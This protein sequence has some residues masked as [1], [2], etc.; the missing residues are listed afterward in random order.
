MPTSWDRVDE[1]SAESFPASDPP[2]WGSSHASTDVERP[3]WETIRDP[4]LTRVLIVISDH[5]QARTIADAIRLH[6]L[7]LGFVVEVADASTGGAPPPSDYDA[8]IVGATITVSTDRAI[9]KY[10]RDHRD[11]LRQIPSAMFVVACPGQSAGFAH[12]VFETGWRP[13]RVATVVRDG[14]LR[15]WLA[16]DA[17][18]ADA[19]RMGTRFASEL[20]GITRLTP[21]HAA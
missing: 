19:R 21:A 5:P 9:V 2:G 11:A 6:L 7:I 17:C 14:P 4:D 3:Y 10:I 15:H 13:V 1:A 16:P 8:I 18:A 12:F 20:V